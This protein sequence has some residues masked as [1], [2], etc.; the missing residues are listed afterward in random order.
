MS[1]QERSNDSRIKGDILLNIKRGPVSSKKC[2]HPFCQEQQSLHLVPMN[3]RSKLIH[4]M[5][6]YVPPRGV[7]CDNHR[8]FGQWVEEDIRDCD[9]IPYTAVIIEEMVDLLRFK[10]KSLKYGSSKQ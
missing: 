2:V 5:R 9:L 1:S 4:E 8:C 7:V 6:F 3:V 10:P